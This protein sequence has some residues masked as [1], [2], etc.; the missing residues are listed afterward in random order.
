[1]NRNARRIILNGEM[2][3]V[4]LD[5]HTFAA[6]VCCLAARTHG[7]NAVVDQL[8]YGVQEVDVLDEH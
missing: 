8:H 2:L 1:M 7:V 6:N 3:V 5:L 4:V